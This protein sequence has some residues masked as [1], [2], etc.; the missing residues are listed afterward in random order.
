[1]R[2]EIIELITIKTEEGNQFDF[3]RK[4]L[5]GFSSAA[6]PLYAKI[7]EEVGLHH[8]RPAEILPEVKTI[9]SFFL[10]FS[11]KVVEANRRGHDV[12]AQ[13]WVDSYA[14]ANNLIG[15]TSQDLADLV[16]SR[17]FKAA[18]VNTIKNYDEKTLKAS[19]SH[20]SAAFLS[21]LGRFGLS[22]MLIT[23]AGGAGRYGTILISEELLPSV[24]PEEEL[25]LFW[26]NGSCRY[27]LEHCP[28]KAL[29]DD[30]D[31]FDRQAC[32]LNLN[33]SQGVCGKCA[34]GPCAIF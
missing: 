12:P 27:C 34:V 16:A 19:W 22:R 13:E 2:K 18:L 5:V 11:K 30:P 1:M 20:R 15:K 29:D 26:K 28:V 6:D 7:K 17:G 21:G 25:C 23:P 32:Q 24:R 10:P 8:L 33:K 14:H 9:V 4:P 3:Y 31:K